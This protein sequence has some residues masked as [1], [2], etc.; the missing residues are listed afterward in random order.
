[1]NSKLLK[2][3]IVLNRHTLVQVASYLEISRSAL[4]RKMSGE[5]DFT[6]KEVLKL[7]SLLKL[8]NDQVMGIFF[9]EEVS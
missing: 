8:S 1:M 9:N 2:S 4:Y 3:Q 6:R 5:S 7:K